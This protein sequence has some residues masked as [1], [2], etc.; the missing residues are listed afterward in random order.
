MNAFVPFHLFTA[1][2]VLVQHLRTKPNDA[3]I[4]A[5]LKFLISALKAMKRKNPLAET[6]LV[7]V[8]SDLM[9]SGADDLR[10]YRDTEPGDI[11]MAL[12]RKTQ[13]AQPKRLDGYLPDHTDPCGPLDITSIGLATL[14]H[15]DTTASGIP[16]RQRNAPSFG[17][18]HDSDRLYERMDTTIDAGEF[19]RP[20]PPSGSRSRVNTVSPNSVSPQSQEQQFASQDHRGFPIQK[21]MM[22]Q[23]LIRDESNATVANG[24]SAETLSL[25][26]DASMGLIHQSIV[27]VEFS[28]TDV[29]NGIS[30]AEWSH[31]LN[32]YG[33]SN[34][35]Q[36]A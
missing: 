31:M 13:Q 16:S 36:L 28:S 14:D 6:F 26:D 12:A 18:I 1:A 24:G 35:D 25:W 34:A 17:M 11:A 22:A 3:Q 32:T 27:G 33:G 10:V 4:R 21:G 15:E 2:R 29:L 23:T 5:S 8:D 19:G 20:T 7:H 9:G 30:D